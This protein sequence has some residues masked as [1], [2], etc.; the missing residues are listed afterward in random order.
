M[1]LYWLSHD[2][3]LVDIFRYDDLYVNQVD[4]NAIIYEFETCLTDRL[5]GNGLSVMLDHNGFWV[6]GVIGHLICP[7]F[8]N[9]SK[10]LR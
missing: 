3:W 5:G 9:I 10:Q 8:E 2:V 1:D 4:N 7:E 6:S